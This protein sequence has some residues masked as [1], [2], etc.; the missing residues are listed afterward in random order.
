MVSG[1]KQDVFISFA[2]SIMH[3]IMSAKNGF[4][5]FNQPQIVVFLSGQGKIGSRVK[6]IH[7]SDKQSKSKRI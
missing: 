2:N 4:T 7:A 1:G 3:S 6:A 5:I